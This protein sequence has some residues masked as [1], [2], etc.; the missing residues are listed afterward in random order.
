MDNNFCETLLLLSFLHTIMLLTV[1]VFLLNNV[2]DIT[3]KI[4]EE[5]FTTNSLK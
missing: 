2:C 5:S 4:C 1:C 3:A